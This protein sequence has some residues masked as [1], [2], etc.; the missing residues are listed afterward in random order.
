M[1]EYIHLAGIDAQILEF[2]DHAAMIG[3]E[4][5]RNIFGNYSN[6]K[7]GIQVLAEY[8]EKLIYR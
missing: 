2:S 3:K 6:Q 8:I 1:P 7:V 4:F 5:Q